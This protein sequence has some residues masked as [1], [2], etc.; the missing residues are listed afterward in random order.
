MNNNL[1]LTD[2]DLETAKHIFIEQTDINM[3]DDEFETMVAQVEM[4][5]DVEFAA[6]CDLT[7]IDLQRDADFFHQMMRNAPQG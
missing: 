6:F 5:N 2:S 4:M 7:V 1:Y 3:P